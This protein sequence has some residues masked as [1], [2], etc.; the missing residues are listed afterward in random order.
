MI[1]PEKRKRY[2]YDNIEKLYIDYSSAKV[3]DK[4]SLEKL[5][6][7]IEGRKVLILV[8][9]YSLKEYENQIQKTID[10]ENPV[11]ISVNFVDDTREGSYS[12]FGN[13]KR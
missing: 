7:E 10:A 9:G 11:V 2:D 3:D 1:E 8:P 4:L 5:Q 12:F 13:K 6:K